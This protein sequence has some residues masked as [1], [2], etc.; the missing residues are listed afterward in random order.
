MYSGTGLLCTGFG[1][2][3]KQLLILLSSSICSSTTVLTHNSLLPRWSFFSSIKK[4][5]SGCPLDHAVYAILVG[6]LGR[7]KSRAQTCMR[8]GGF[9]L[10]FILQNRYGSKSVCLVIRTGLNI[11]YC[12][13]FKTCS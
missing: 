6:K 2:C 1:Y 10:L 7:S 13:L 8:V 5:F 9:S 3:C 4:H 11:I 12:I